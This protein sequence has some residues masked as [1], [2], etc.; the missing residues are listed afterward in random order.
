[1]LIAPR[2]DESAISREPRAGVTTIRRASLASRPKEIGL[3]ILRS[4]ARR[5]SRERLARFLVKAD[6]GPRAAS[7]SVSAGHEDR[8]RYALAGVAT[9]VLVAVVIC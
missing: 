7:N 1:M 2:G 5:E 3:A 4:A 8:V 6:L 9:T